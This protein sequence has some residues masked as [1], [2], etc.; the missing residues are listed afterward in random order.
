MTQPSNDDLAIDPLWQRLQHELVDDPPRMPEAATLR[1]LATRRAARAPMATLRRFS[2]WSV[3][4]ALSLV[5]V[6]WAAKIVHAI[7]QVSR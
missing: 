4:G 1:G 2:E 5:S 6:A 3:V 7:Y